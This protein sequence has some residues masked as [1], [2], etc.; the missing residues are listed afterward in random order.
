MRSSALAPLSW[1]CA[2]VAVA[3]VAAALLLIPSRTTRAGNAAGPAAATPGDAADAT[4]KDDKNEKNEKALAAMEL[5]KSLKGTW[6]SDEAGPDGKQMQ[7]EF[8]VTAGGSAVVETMFPGAKHE[9]VNAYHLDGERVI[10]TH[11]CAQGVQPRMRLA[12]HEGNTL[13]FDFMDCTNL[14]PGEGHMGTLELTI[15]PDKL[16][17]KWGYIKDGKSGEATEFQLHRKK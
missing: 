6:E 15:E 10:A 8:R 4:D 7:L 2:A 13:K 5:I 9:M 11:Y 12:S 14:K 16:T 17:E 1:S 3:F